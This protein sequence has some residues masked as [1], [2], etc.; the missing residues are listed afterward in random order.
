MNEE[1]HIYDFGSEC[2]HTSTKKCECG[3]CI[4]ISTQQDNNAEYIT[5]IFVRCVCGKSV[6]FDVPVN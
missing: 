2:A 1:D 3:R 6:E 4:E 5:T